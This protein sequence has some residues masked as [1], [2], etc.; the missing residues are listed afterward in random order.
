MRLTAGEDGWRA[1]PTKD[2]QGSHVLTSM[3]G[4]DA[5]ALIAPGEGEAAAGELRGGGAAVRRRD[6]GAL[7]ERRRRARARVNL[8]APAAL[9]VRGRTAA[10]GRSRWPRSRC[11]ARSWSGSGRPSTSSASRAPTGASS[12]ASRSGCCACSTPTTSREVVLLGRARSCCCASR[13][14]STRS[15]ADGGTVTWPIDRGLLVAPNGRGRGF[16]RLGVRRLPS[17]DD[18][19]AE[20]TAVVTS[21]VVNF[22]PRDRRLG[23]VRPHRPLPLQPDAAAHPRDRDQRVPAL[24]GEPGAGAVRGRVAAAASPGARPR[25]PAASPDRGER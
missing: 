12:R 13:R 15:S 19:A 4:A 22:Y 20:A 16:L 18:G 21:E 25:S 23:L 5:L 14:P 24:A 1:S 3:L 8:R 7:L 6:R 11:R 10:S 17:A 2:A 9:G